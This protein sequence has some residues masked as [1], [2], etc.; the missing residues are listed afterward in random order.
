MQISLIYCFFEFDK[1]GASTKK[2]CP[3]NYGYIFLGNNATVRPPYKQQPNKWLCVNSKEI[4]YSERMSQVSV[5]VLGV[6]CHYPV[7][8]KMD[9]LS[10]FMTP[11]PHIFNL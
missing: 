10:C 3:K 2:H 1:N 7:Y 11:P 9:S 8:I 6:Y 5:C 4:C